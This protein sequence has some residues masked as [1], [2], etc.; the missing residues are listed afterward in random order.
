MQPI[1]AAP[2]LF[3]GP[4]VGRV[5][6]F[7]VVVG[8]G[9][10]LESGDNTSTRKHSVYVLYDDDST[11][12][13]SS[14]AIVGISGRSR[15]QL[16]TVDTTTN[17]INVT[18]FTWGRPKTDGDTTQ[19]SGW[20]FDLPGTGEKLVYSIRNLGSL[21]AS[22]ST[23]T[24]GTSGAVA[25]CSTDA[26][27]SKVYTVNVGDGGGSFD[28]V[29][30]I[31]GEFLVLEKAID[32]GG[33]TVTPYDSTGRATRKIVKQPVTIGT[34]GVGQSKPVEITETIGRLSWR[35]IYNY[36]DLKNK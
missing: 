32:T 35:Q 34:K 2:G 22:F 30:G 11:A 15:L 1:T 6:T 31:T 36:Q 9:K 18:K 10:Y 7:Y 14:P 23:L 5:N 28:P 19:R 29:D 8:T 4:V 25:A 24:P 17:K 21:T 20:Y 16:G 12:A 27:T 13:D 33:S 26:G 3:T